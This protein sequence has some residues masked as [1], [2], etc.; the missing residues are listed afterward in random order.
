MEILL[1]TEDSHTAQKRLMGN[2]ENLRHFTNH[3][4]CITFWLKAMIGYNV[5]MKMSKLPMDDNGVAEKDFA[6]LKTLLIGDKI[7]NDLHNLHHPVFL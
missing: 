6:L 4:K 7:P 5:C 3:D 2:I 1:K